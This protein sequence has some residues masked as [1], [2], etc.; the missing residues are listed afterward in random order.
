MPDLWNVVLGKPWVDAQTL[1]EAIEHEAGQ[2]DLDYRTRLL[3][4]DGTQALQAHWGPERLA[5]WL[6]RSRTRTQIESI[7]NER[8]GEIGFPSLKERL[9][10]AITPTTIQRYFRELSGHVHRPIRLVIGGSVALILE[11]YLARGTEDI[12]VVDEVP[13]ELRQQHV[14]LERLQ[15][16]YGLQLTHFQSH[17]LPSG[18]EGRVGSLE[19]FGQLQVA[20]IDPHDLFLSKLF[21]A[22]EKDR[23]DL[24][25]LL[26][27]LDAEVVKARL[28]DTCGAL[29]SDPALRRHAEQ[30]WYVLTGQALP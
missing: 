4:R 21:S 29:L 17:F 14:L 30:N 11:G 5:R 18:W 27:P 24:L 26:P 12:D 7:Q 15:T 10:D 20:L 16:T 23:R 8:F 6:H 2:P 22:R 9:V 28:K 25:A 13:A 3:I 1:A 19:P